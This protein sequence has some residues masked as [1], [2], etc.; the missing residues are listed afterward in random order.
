MKGQVDGG[1]KLMLL[2]PKELDQAKGPCFS[3]LI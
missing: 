1:L 2:W 3:K